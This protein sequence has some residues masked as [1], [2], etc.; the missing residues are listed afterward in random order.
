MI[1]VVTFLWKGW[2]PIYTAEHV[3]IFARMVR[4]NFSLPHKIICVTNCPD[5]ITECETFPLWEQQVVNQNRVQ[6]CYVRLRLFDPAT[7][8]QLGEK[9]LVMD[10]DTVILND[11]APLI[12]N[13]D[14]CAVK[15]RHAPLNGSMFM[16]KSGT[17]AHVWENW[18]PRWS[19]KQIEKTRHKMLYIV[20]SDQAWMSIQLPDAA[21]WTTCD[22]VEHYTLLTG[23]V[24]V[25]HCKVVFFAGKV[26]PWS[27]ECRRDHPELY[28]AYQKFS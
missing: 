21:K 19:P 25:D 5:G 9:L 4:A 12:T 28:S 1:T 24:N 27:D 23:Q 18:D 10:L 11:L 20:G 22:G 15:G 14:F 6:D 26:K 16:I 8:F 2:N 3:N 13:D 17:N 7:A